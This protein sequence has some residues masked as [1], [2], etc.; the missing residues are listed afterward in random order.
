MLPREL[1]PPDAADT[2]YALTHEALYLRLTDEC[3]CSPSRY[4]HWLSTT[5]T[6]VLTTAAHQDPP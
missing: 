4:A 5:L 2:I 1:H 6:V 3:G